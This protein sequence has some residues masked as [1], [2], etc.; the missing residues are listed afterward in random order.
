MAVYYATKAYVLSFT[1]SLAE[2]LLGTG[3]TVTALC[4]GPTATNFDIN[5]RLLGVIKKTSMSAESVARIGHRA[6]RRGKVVSVTGLR[7]QIPAFPPRLF[8]RAFV[9]KVTKRLN[10]VGYG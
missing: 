7:D 10:R 1:E 4:P 3:V 6:F 9:R 8:P 5:M 2:E